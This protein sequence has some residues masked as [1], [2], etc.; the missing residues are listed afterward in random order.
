V[1]FI[2]VAVL[3]GAALA[4][5]TDVAVVFDQYRRHYGQPVV[6]GQ[7]LAWLTENA[8]ERRLTIFAAHKGEDLVG[9]ATTVALPASLRLS[10]YWQLRDLYVVPGARRCGAGRALLSAVSQAAI[11]AGALRISVQT[12]SGNAAALPHQRLHPGG[13]SPRPDAAPPPWRHLIPD[14]RPLCGRPCIRPGP[15]KRIV[16]RVRW[17]SAC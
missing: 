14:E 7:T 1:V 10:C 5:L 12:E 13:G 8:G 9:L 4:Q 11:A 6:P 16:M 17:S 15:P 2:R 3:T